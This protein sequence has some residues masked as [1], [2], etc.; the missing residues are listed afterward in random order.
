MFKKGWHNI[1]NQSLKFWKHVIYMIH[2]GAIK[3]A[4][5][6]YTSLGVRILQ[7]YFQ[8]K[9]FQTLY[10]CTNKNLKIFSLFFLFYTPLPSTFSTTIQTFLTSPCLRRALLLVIIIRRY[11]PTAGYTN[12]FFFMNQQRISKFQHWKR[13]KRFSVIVNRLFINLDNMDT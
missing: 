1:Y 2:N 13:E 3:H 7:L 5:F 4:V 8:L 6:R 11:V 10:I 9:E 12:I